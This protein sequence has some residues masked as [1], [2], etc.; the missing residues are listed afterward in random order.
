MFDK[1]KNL[2]VK[3]TT[4]HNSLG[5]VTRNYAKAPVFDPHRQVTGITYKAIDKIGQSLS[6]YKPIVQ[7]PNGEPY[8]NHPILNLYKKPNPR[9]NGSFFTHLYAMLME[10]YGETFW[11][12]AKGEL[13]NKPKEIYLLPPEQV[14]L[15]FY[16]SEL[17][18]YVLHKN[19]GSQIPLL[20]EEVI[21]VKRPNPFNEWRGLSI[22]EKA[23]VYIDTEIV[24]SSFT[25]NYIK[26]AASP[27]G[28]VSLPDMDRD[29]FNAFV[30]QW[31]EGY[32]GPENAGKTGFIRGEQAKFQ[33]VGSTL[34]D[35][36]QEITR[37]MAKEDVL[38]ML[39]V[40]KPLLGATDDVG[41]GRGNLDVL[42]T[43]FAENKTEPMMLQLDNVWLEIGERLDKRSSF[44]VT[45]TS[46]I[47]EDKSYKLDNYKAGANVWLT[48]NEIRAEQGMKPL[49][50]GD[51]LMLDNK[52]NQSESKKS[53]VNIKKISLKKKLTK[54]EIIKK[55]EQDRETY[56]KSLMETSDLYAKD[57]KKTIAE[58]ASTQ[59]NAIID[60]INATS[61]SF[62][63]WLF[64]IKDES[65]ALA[66]L[67]SPILIDLMEAQFE[68]V[69]NYITGELI[70]VTPQIKKEIQ[71]Q[72]LRVSGLYN[73]E[74]L[75]TLEKTLTEGSINNE[76]L[77]K[78]K[79]RVEQ[80]YSDARGYRA[81]RI[82]QTESLRATN[83][84]AEIVFKENGFD[85]TQWFVNPNA[86]EFCI[87]MAGKTKEIGAKFV[88]IGEVITTAN[89]DQMKI[90]YDDVYNPPLHPNCKCSI[91][92]V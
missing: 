48:V 42:K 75:R 84:S 81:E 51:E 87:T 76:S 22:L 69:A 12:L 28:I 6:V 4:L 55:K 8:T 10:I 52:I 44:A 59:E 1:F 90:D 65:E 91:D 72:I 60:K 70:T 20:L 32:E 39:D 35:I 2:F 40:P 14:E 36:D 13:T 45:H 85:R 17:V 73:E 29:A 7:K 18:G 38:M 77:T 66:F 41:F 92:P 71:V 63:E 56:R 37:K 33:A 30:S 23:A 31:R 54:S 11:Y 25:M 58:F 62:E 15:K 83:K 47:P 5:A 74:T 53:E 27:S 26:N 89:G 46:P 78:L 79:K 43:I 88:N 3:K 80:V 21:H 16:N 9:V 86:C 49:P 24:T 68:E 34:K 82:A 61:K 67:I 50:N 57:V 19:N 64:N